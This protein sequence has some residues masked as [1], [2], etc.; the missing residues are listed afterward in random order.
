MHIKQHIAIVITMLL[1]ASNAV[2]AA[3]VEV[4]I[5]IKDHRFIPDKLTVPADKRVKILIKN[6]DSTPEEFESHSLNREKMVQG[7]SQTNIFIGP[8]KAG[9]YPFFGEYN[10]KTAQ[11]VITAK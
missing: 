4:L 6:E 10:N 1:A 11:G 3:D 7:N 8:L 5:R 2:L 9:I